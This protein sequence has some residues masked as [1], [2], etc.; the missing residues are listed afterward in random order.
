MGLTVMVTDNKRISGF[1]YPKLF[2]L[3]WFELDVT[4]GELRLGQQCNNPSA[5]NACRFTAPMQKVKSLLPRARPTAD[6]L[7]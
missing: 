3:D 5:F 6:L 1:R 7:P 4:S 2:H